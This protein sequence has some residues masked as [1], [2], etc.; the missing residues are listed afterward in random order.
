M[1]RFCR[2]LQISPNLKDIEDPISFLQIFADRVRAGL[3]STQGQLIKKR[4]VEQYLLSVG[5][6]FASVGSNDPQHNQVGKLYFLLGRQLASYKKNDSTSTIVWPLDVIFIQALD[7][8]AQSTTPINIAI[9]DLTWVAFFFLLRP[10]EY[11]RGGTNT[12]Q[13]SFRL[14]DFQFFIGQ[15]PYNAVTASNAVLA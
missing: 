7:T 14:K 9:S 4:S 6:I 2:W 10:G 1:R 3:L 15:Q 11:C 5:Q 12:S 13:H 8:A